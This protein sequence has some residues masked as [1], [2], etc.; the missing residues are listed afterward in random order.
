MPLA[1]VDRCIELPLTKASC[2]IAN[3]VH[4]ARSE[5]LVRGEHEVDESQFMLND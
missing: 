1:G 2:W 4:V 5:R 3:G